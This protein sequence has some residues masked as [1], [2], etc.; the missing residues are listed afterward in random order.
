[1]NAKGSKLALFFPVPDEKGKAS[2]F[3]FICSDN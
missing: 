2:A 3:K 1:M